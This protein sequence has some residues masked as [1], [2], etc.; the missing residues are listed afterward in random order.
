MKHVIKHGCGHIADSLFGYA[1]NPIECPVCVERHK[2]AGAFCMACKQ[3][4]EPGEKH[5]CKTTYPTTPEQFIAPKAP[6]AICYR[7]GNIRIMFNAVLSAW[8][9]P[10]SLDKDNVF[11]KFGHGKDERITL[12]GDDAIRFLAEYDAW[13]A[14][15]EGQQ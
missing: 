2:H 13:I 15:Q 7:E 6:V 14:W 4:V 10:W 1:Q 11:V 9:E 3:D 8:N 5:V 12:R